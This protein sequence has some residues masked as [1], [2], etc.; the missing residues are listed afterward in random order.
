MVVNNVTRFVSH[1]D[2]ADCIRDNTF[3]ESYTLDPR[4]PTKGEIRVW[5][6]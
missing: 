6:C 5:S 1:K 3:R 4:T 2:A